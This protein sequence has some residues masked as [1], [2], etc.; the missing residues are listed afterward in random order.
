MERTLA[1][2]GA[3]S[4]DETEA[5]KE[6][7][8]NFLRFMRGL[9]EGVHRLTED[10]RDDLVGLRPPEHLADLHDTLMAEL[11]QSIE[12]VGWALDNLD[13]VDTD[14]ENQDEYLEFLVSLLDFDGSMPDPSSLGAET[15][16]ELR[17]RLEAELGRDVAICD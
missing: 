16:F 9:F 15:C 12:V 14:I 6:F 1:S 5:V 8:E 13:D 17:D 10:Y 2:D 7:A 11:D 3:W 4:D